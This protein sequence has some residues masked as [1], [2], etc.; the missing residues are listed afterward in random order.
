MEIIKG[1]FFYI[2]SVS[3]EDL[4]SQIVIGLK[5]KVVKGVSKM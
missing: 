4:C 5:T 1:D 3:V 2:L